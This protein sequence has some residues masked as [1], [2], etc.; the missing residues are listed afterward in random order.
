[1]DVPLDLDRRRRE[2]LQQQLFK[3]IR[4]AVLD[5]RLRPGASLPASRV[6]ATQ[7]NVSR[8]TVLLTYERLIAEGYLQSRETVGT[9]VSCELPERCLMPAPRA[10]GDCGQ[11]GGG[12]V[13]GIAFRGR[14]QAV[15]S[16]VALS[17][18]FWLGRADPG[19][20]PLKAWRRIASR[21]LDRGGRHL[22]QYADPRGLPRLREA[23]AGHLGMARG[24]KVAPEQVI[25]TSG[26]Q[27]GLNL[28][29]RLLLAPGARVG[30]E[31]PCYQGAAFLFESYGAQLVP[32]PVD[33]AGIRVASLP[34]GD[35]RLLYLTP[36]HQYP[37][38]YT[39]PLDRRLELLEWV[40]ESG[41]FLVEDDYDSDFRYRGAPLT[42]LA[43][44]D[45]RGRTIYPGTFSKSIG[46][47]L[48]LGYLVVPLALAEEAATAKALLDNGHP[49][50]DQ[51]VM[52]EF[53]ANGQYE[54]HLRRIRK[55]YG[56]RRDCLVDELRSRFG[57]VTLSGLEGGM[58]LAWH[59]PEE[60]APAAELQDRV[61]RQGVGIYTLGSGAAFD[62]GGC[63]YSR[64]TVLLGYSSLSPDRIRSGVDI[65]ARCA[66]ETLS[67]R[68]R[69]RR[70]AA[71][72]ERSA[73]ARSPRSDV[74]RE[75]TA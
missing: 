22:T 1:M 23:I 47:G 64:H 41:A 55:L 9:F 70:P 51:A 13:S 46:A 5:G 61:R 59:L 49:W 27:E 24:M 6:L 29:A 69:R 26:S 58:H 52:S 35:I 71:G 43:G 66:E 14:A 18:D 57:E 62:F 16:N 39:L 53:I 31:N 45:E 67:R 20:F 4:R 34:S 75:R 36:S 33:E 42:A 19:S 38:G 30:I 44:L 10:Q 65:M 63:G 21:A 11:A 2:P 48:R 73:A 72:R 56:E 25:I 68:G 28:V 32:C 8:N 3:K 40:R 60:L 7:L 12:D 15:V 54:S 17:C 37:L 74:G 50:L